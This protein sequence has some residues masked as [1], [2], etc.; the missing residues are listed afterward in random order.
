MTPAVLLVALLAM[1]GSAPTRLPA[2]DLGRAPR[3]LDTR[4]ARL[5]AAA[6]KADKA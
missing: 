4:L 1:Q 5:A 6:G 2:E 3:L